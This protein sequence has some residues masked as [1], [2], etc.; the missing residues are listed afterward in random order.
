MRILYVEDNEDSIDMLYW[1]SVFVPDSSNVRR[2]AC[3][4]GGICTLAGT[5]R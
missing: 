4:R 3:R 5:L 1:H 2:S